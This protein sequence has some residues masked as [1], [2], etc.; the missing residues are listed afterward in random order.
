M[1]LKMPGA[2]MDYYVVGK[3]EQAAAQLRFDLS[4]LAQKPGVALQAI[5]TIGDP[6]H[7]DRRYVE[8]WS[9]LREKNFASPSGTKTRPT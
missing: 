7:P 2:S 8:D 9:K 3:P 5:I 1:N 6:A 4:G